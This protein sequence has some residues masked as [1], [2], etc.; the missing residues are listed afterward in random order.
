MLPSQDQMFQNPIHPHYLLHLQ[1]ITLL[2]VDLHQWHLQ[3]E[4]QINHQRTSFHHIMLRQ[5][6]NLRDTMQ[7]LPPHSHS[8]CLLQITDLI[9][10]YIILQLQDLQQLWALYHLLQEFL[11]LLLRLHPSRGH[12]LVILEFPF[13]LL[14]FLLL[15]LQ[16]GKQRD[17][18]HHQF[19]HYRLHHPMQIAHTLRAPSLLQIRLL[20]HPVV[21]S[22]RCKL[23]CALVCLCIH[24]SLWYQSCPGKLQL[25]YL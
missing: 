17:H 5:N 9:I 24:F 14:K 8:K 4:H 13:S 20:D 15:G 7:M 21:V 2:V 11:K 1:A 12:R 23:G 22:G 19:G 6:L 25:G 3:V 18:L 10:H 16:Q